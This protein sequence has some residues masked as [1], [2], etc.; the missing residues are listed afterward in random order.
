MGMDI[1][2]GMG[3]EK[4]LQLCSPGTGSYALGGCHRTT[5]PQN[6]YSWE[7]S[8]RSSSPT[9]HLPPILPTI[10]V[11]K[12][13]TYMSREHLQEKP[14]DEPEGHDSSPRFL[15]LQDLHVIRE[16]LARIADIHRC[17]CNTGTSV[18]CCAP[19]HPRASPSPEGQQ[20]LGPCS[21]PMP[22]CTWLPLPQFPHG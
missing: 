19:H 10:H 5:E 17:F 2:A 12:C 14:P 1:Q 4:H 9:A 21:S 11:P 3:K 15:L 6:H 7:R 22:S 8:L 18:S 16:Q 20:V 13:H